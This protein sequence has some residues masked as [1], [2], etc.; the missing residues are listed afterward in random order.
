MGQLKTLFGVTPKKANNFF[1]QLINV[2]Q[3]LPQTQ[4]ITFLIGFFSF[5]FLYALTKLKLKWKWVGFIPGPIV[6]VLLFTILSY[7][8]DLNSK[9]VAIVG[10]IPPG[11]P[12]ASVPNFSGF[13]DFIG[14][15]ITVAFI[16]FLEHISIATKFAEMQGYKVISI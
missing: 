13:G 1:P 15:A 6:L 12:K 3:V 14:P 4:Y 11:L 8:I 7:T 2:I 9:G 10:Y 5:A 16:G